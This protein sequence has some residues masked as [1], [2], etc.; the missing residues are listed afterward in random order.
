[1]I[2]VNAHKALFH[3]SGTIVPSFRG[4]KWDFSNKP[5]AIN[6]ELIECLQIA[7]DDVCILDVDGIETV[8]NKI[9]ELLPYAVFLSSIKELKN[10]SM[11]GS[12]IAIV[13]HGNFDSILM[14]LGFEKRNIIQP[15]F[16]DV[17][18]TLDANGFDMR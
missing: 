17:V 1:M 16:T 3:I 11:T 15:I 4:F 8:N 2:F 14:E 7:G 13:E 10:I 12:K 5:Y 6:L 9:K 18:G